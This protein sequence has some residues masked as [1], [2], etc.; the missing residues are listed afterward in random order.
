MDL[1]FEACVDAGPDA[2][3]LHAAAASTIKARVANI[4][5]QL[6]S[7]PLPVV[8]DHSYGLVDYRLLRELLFHFLYAPYGVA[9]RPTAQ[10][11]SVALVAVEAGDGRPLWELVAGDQPNIVCP[12]DND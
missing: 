3:A 8:S 9:P 4:T 1:F 11:L 7:R 12:C 2:C 6:K 5:A 10:S